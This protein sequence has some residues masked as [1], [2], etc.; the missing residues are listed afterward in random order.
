M[1][2]EQQFKTVMQTFSPCNASGFI[3]KQ[4]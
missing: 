4:R 1:E 3:R 2:V